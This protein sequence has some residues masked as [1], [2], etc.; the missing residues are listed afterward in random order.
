[1]FISIA[2]NDRGWR[3]RGSIAQECK[4]GYHAHMTQLGPGSLGRSGTRRC[5]VCISI[6]QALYLLWLGWIDD[7]APY[8]AKFVRHNHFTVVDPMH[9]AGTLGQRLDEH[10]LPIFQVI[11]APH[12][13]SFVVGSNS[14][15]L[16][17]GRNS[18]DA[19]ETHHMRRYRSIRIHACVQ[20]PA[21]LT[22][23]RIKYQDVTSSQR[24]HIP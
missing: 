22:C 17:I 20:R 7:K 8:I 11:D 19:W 5:D 24:H 4:T 12:T 10:F 15:I 18:T 6:G 13:Q 2:S 21:P 3:I 16:L 23:V 14:N 9:R 1:M